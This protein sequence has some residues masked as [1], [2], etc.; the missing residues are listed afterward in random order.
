MIKGKREA[1]FLDAPL[2]YS[3]GE[4]YVAISGGL[5]DSLVH[6]IKTS[7]ILK[8][9]LPDIQ[10]DPVQRAVADGQ[11]QN[12]KF[13]NAWKK[14]FNCP[15]SQFSF[16]M[17]DAAHFLDLAAKKLNNEQFMKRM[18][19]RVQHFHVKLGYGKRHQIAENLGQQKGVRTC[20]LYTSDAADE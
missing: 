17:W 1:W 8:D 14:E 3:V 16:L 15:D 6:Q 10:L 13:M 19:K 20:L 12:E 11:F 18:I 7:L 9:H 5:S 4:G 2:V